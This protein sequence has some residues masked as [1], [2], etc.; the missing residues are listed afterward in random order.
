MR[1]LLY[2]LIPIAVLIAGTGLHRARK[3]R[4]PATR[5]RAPQAKAPSNPTTPGFPAPGSATPQSNRHRYHLHRPSWL[6]EGSNVYKIQG[7]NEY[8]LLVEAIGEGR[9][10]FRSWTASSLAGP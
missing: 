4:P 8:L 9:R 3:R 7:R 5:L 6:F 1:R 10:M 2:F